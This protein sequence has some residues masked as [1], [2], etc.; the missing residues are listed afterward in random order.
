M[1]AT[2]TPTT[3]FPRH[4]VAFFASGSNF[5]VLRSTPVLRSEVL[6][7]ENF[8]V[9]THDDDVLDESSSVSSPQP[10]TYFPETWLWQLSVL[11]E[12]GVRSERVSLP[13]TITE[14]VGKAV[15][16]H[17][18]KGLGVS[19]AASITTFTPFFID[20]TLPPSVKRGEI[21]NVKISVFNYLD[22]DLP[23]KVVLEASPEYDILEAPGIGGGVVVETE[24]GVVGDDVGG[25]GKHR[26]CIP[27]QDKTVHTVRLRPKTLGD[28]NITVWAEVD[29][30]YPDVCGPEY[31]LSKRD[32][33]VKAIKVDIEGYPK[34]KTWTKYICSKDIEANSDSLESWH[35][36]LPSTIVPDSAR[37]WVTT[38]GDLLGPT[39]ENLGSLVKMPYGCGEQNMLNFSPNIFILQYLEASGQTTPEIA[40]KAIDYM[41]QGYQRELRYRHRVGSYSAFGSSDAEGSTWLT[42]FVL[43]S[44]ALARQFIQVDSED[45]NMSREWLRSQQ[46]EN[47]CF[48]SRGKVFHKGMKGGLDNGGSPVP[49]AAYILVSLLESGELSTSRTVSEAAFCLLADNTQ[50]PYTLALKSYALALA[51]APE[52]ETV[53]QQLIALATVTP[54]SMYWDLPAG[55]GKSKGVAVE[56]AGYAILAMTTL[57]ANLYH[58]NTF[59][60]VKWISSQRNGQGG[61]ISTQDTVVALQA[62]ASFESHQEVGNGTDLV[63]TVDAGPLQHNFHIDNINK[64][65]LQS[66]PSLPSLPTT[67]SLDMVGEGCALIQAV[68]RYN[69]PEDQATEAFS[70]SVETGTRHDP[71]CLTKSIKVCASYQLP[72]N[73]S[74]MAVVEVN[75]VSGYIPIKADL[76]RIVG[77]GTGLIKR[78]EVDGSLVTFYVDEFTRRETCLEFGMIRHVDVEHVKPGTVKVYDYY[79]PEYFTTQS[80]TLPDECLTEPEPVPEIEGIIVSPIRIE[81]SDYEY[82]GEEEIEPVGVVREP[83]EGGVNEAGAGVNEGDIDNLLAVLDN[84][85]MP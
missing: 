33:L 80:Y 60:I 47:G 43:K 55:S 18:E 54:T 51:S 24:V 75:L 4:R 56:V 1:I 77:Y 59:K 48:Q 72:D 5:G 44:F 68:L 73:T 26:S 64:L 41:K 11:P 35:M 20:L 37:G 14:W 71:L 28:V 50:D 78:Y 22:A 76:K 7:L 49:L 30:L 46:M 69:V 36:T 25:V 9:H 52:A 21:L 17:Q 58:H 63:V 85:M 62:L 19:S 6:E 38:V 66:T 79:Q 15:C 67:V 70:L 23:V 40:E 53:V 3:V 42:A 8:S 32:H 13:H 34:E 16:V 57:D 65:L 82:Y 31:V 81:G 83:G 45:I 27:A 39:L 10:R 84:T 29:P 12:S 61:F 74:N 2:L